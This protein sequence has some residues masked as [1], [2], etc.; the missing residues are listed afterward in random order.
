MTIEQYSKNVVNKF[1]GVACTLE[2]SLVTPVPRVGAVS[3]R[4]GLPFLGLG[5]LLVSG[6]DY[7]FDTY[8]Y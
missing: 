4:T 2:V 6:C 5:G 3:M 1:E 8:S 7:N